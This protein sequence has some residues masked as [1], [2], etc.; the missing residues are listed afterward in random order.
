MEDAK[1]LVEIRHTLRQIGR[2]HPVKAR[3]RPGPRTIRYQQHL[4]PQE[5]R[6]SQLPAS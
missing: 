5:P 1:D 2:Q 6:K 4:P 3:R